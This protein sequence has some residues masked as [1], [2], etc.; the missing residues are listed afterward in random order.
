MLGLSGNDIFQPHFPKKTSPAEFRAFR[1]GLFCGSSL[2]PCWLPYFRAQKSLAANFGSALFPMRLSPR[3]SLRIYVFYRAENS[4]IYLISGDDVTRMN[5]IVPCFRLSISRK[6]L[7]FLPA[8]EKRPFFY[9]SVS[10][11]NSK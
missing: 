11:I 5:H 3:F 8:C 6:P 2:F 1:H 10:G 9:H 4:D 7:F